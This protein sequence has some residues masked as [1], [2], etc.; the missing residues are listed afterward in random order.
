TFT[1]PAKSRTKQPHAATGDLPGAHPAIAAVLGRPGLRSAAALRH[2]DGRG[3]FP[4]GHLPAVHRTGAMVRGLRAALAPPHRRPLR[5]EPE[6]PAALL[7]VPGSDQALAAEPA[8][9]LPRFA[10]GPGRGSAG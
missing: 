3:H 1:F 9:P 2:G 10:A 4:P 8:G 5:R 7:P 6:P